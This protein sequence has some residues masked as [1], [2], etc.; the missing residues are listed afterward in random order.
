LI[1]E[2]GYMTNILPLMPDCSYH[3]EPMT[4]HRVEAIEDTTP[5]EVSTPEA[6]DVVRVENDYG[7][8]SGSP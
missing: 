6:E 5:V 2:N 4:N 1:T 8:A 3:V 7:R